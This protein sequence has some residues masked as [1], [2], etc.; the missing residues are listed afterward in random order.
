[1]EL[2]QLLELFENALASF[3]FGGR[4]RPFTAPRRPTSRTQVLHEW[5]TAALALR[6]TGYAALRTLVIAGYYA[7]PERLAGGRL[8]RAAER[9]STMRPRAGVEGR[10]RAPRPPGNGVW[11]DGVQP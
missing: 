3:L 10:R 6:R 1:M 5:L 9:R 11:H 7:V 4:T 2:R 8:P